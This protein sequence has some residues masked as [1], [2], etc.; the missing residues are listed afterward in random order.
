MGEDHGTEAPDAWGST[1]LYGHAA[2]GHR[3]HGSPVAGPMIVYD[4]SL[5]RAVLG[6]DRIDGFQGAK[7]HPMAYP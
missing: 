7:H 3:G 2:T 5:N 4:G 1:G 6:Q